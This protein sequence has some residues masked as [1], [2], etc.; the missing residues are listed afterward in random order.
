M[1]PTAIR[2]LSHVLV[3]SCLLDED[4]AAH[5]QPLLTGFPFGHEPFKI[6]FK[7]RQLAVE[8]GAETHMWT[9]P[10]WQEA[11][12]ISDRSDCGHMSGLMMRSH[13]TA[14]KM[15]STAR[16]PNMVAVSCT[17]GSHGVLPRDCDRSIR[18][19]FRSRASFGLRREAWPHA[20]VDDLRV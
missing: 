4:Q 8:I 15:G 1:Q 20:A 13:M 2:R 12:L 9:A 11:E 19:I 6:G 16:V 17:N 18:S 5:G 14:A 7:C 3:L 10:C